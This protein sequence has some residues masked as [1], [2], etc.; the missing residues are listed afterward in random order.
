MYAHLLEPPPSVTAV[1]PELPPEV[2]ELVAKAMAKSRDDRFATAREFATEAR[3]VLGRGSNGCSHVRGVGGDPTGAGDRARLG[4]AAQRGPGSARGSCDD[5]ERR[6]RRRRRRCSHARPDRRRRRRLE[7]GLAQARVDR[8]HCGPDP[9]RADPGRDPARRRRRRRR[10]STRHRRHHGRRARADPTTL[11]EVLMPTQ[12]ATGCTQAAQPDAGAV[13][14]N[15]CTPTG[16]RAHVVP[17]RR[18]SSRSSATRSRSTR[19]TR[20][21]RTASRSRRLRPAA[22]G[23][24][25]WIHTATGK[26]GGRRALR[27]RQRR[28]LRRRLDAREDRRAGPRR[29]AGHRAR[30]RGAPPPRSRAGGRRSTTIGKCRPK[31]SEETARARSPSSPRSARSRRPTRKAGIDSICKCQQSS[32]RTGPSRDAA[33]RSTRGC[34]SDAWTPT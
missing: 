26:R 25:V 2:D 3:A 9:D 29:H 18:S 28:Q 23:E 6:R 17:E 4:G 21:R 7:A 33:S 1:R 14:T 11:L 20:R 8:R 19:P 13:E 5:R 10:A 16:G 15:D 12:I 24:R 32:S 22:V 34:S 30:S 27:H 31:V